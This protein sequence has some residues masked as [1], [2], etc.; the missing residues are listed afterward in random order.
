MNGVIMINY[1]SNYIPFVRLEKKFYPKEGTLEDRGIIFTGRSLRTEVPPPF[2]LAELIP[3]FTED[4]FC[5]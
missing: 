1:E 3:L 5:S 2:F 4:K